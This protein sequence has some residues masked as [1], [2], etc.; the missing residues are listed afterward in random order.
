MNTKFT[1]L[2]LIVFL[3]FLKLGQ[4]QKSTFSTFRNIDK[5]VKRTPD[6]IANHIISLSDYLLSTAKNDEEKIRAFYMWIIHNIEYKDQMELRYDPNLL[7]YMGSNNCSSPV[8]VLKKRK[9]VCE[10]FSNLFQFFC[11]YAGFDSYAI[12]GYISKDRILQNR[13]TH[14][15]N[16]VKINNNWYF[17]DLSWAYAILHHSGIRSKA[18]E[19]FMLSPEEFIMSHFPIIPMW[20]FLENPISLAQ[21]NAGDEEI[22]KHLNNAPK[23]YVYLDSLLQFNQLSR[24]EQYLKTAREIHKTNP[25]NK[26]N[27]AIEYYRYARTIKNSDGKNDSLQN[28]N[29][30][31]AQEKIKLAISLLENATDISSKIMLL[32]IQDDLHQVNKQINKSNKEPIQNH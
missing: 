13:A 9:A 30:L 27:L 5:Y 21:F 11:S 8:C 19:Y 3:L 23:T 12:S 18:N 16:L 10:G 26:F 24:A 31:K 6:S 32:R 25:N 17:F 20:Q 2:I 22:K 28:S 14:S 1:I 15:W 7:F 4:A 29:L